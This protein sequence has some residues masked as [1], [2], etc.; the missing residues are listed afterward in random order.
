MIKVVI[1]GSGNV[2]QHLIAA[3]SKAHDSGSEIELLQ[4]YTRQPESL[5]PIVDF[6][7][8]TSHLNELAEADLYIIAISDD[9]IADFSSSLPFKNRLVV[10]TSGSLPLEALNGNNRKAVFYP[11]QTF[12]KTR[13][14]DFSNVPIA[15]ESENATD[16]QLLEK[17][18][19]TISEHVY[20]INSIQRKALHVSAVF[21]NNFSNHLYAIANEICNEHQISFELL[22]PLIMETAEKV[23]TLTPREAQT[24]P[25]RRND[26]NTIDSHLALLTND[27]QKAIYNLLTHSIQI[28]EEKL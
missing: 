21:V 3:L 1:I 5:N 27:N 23:M 26:H 11:L 10:H 9:A 19:K 18:A 12:S 13:E 14:V 24:G 6:D 20:A 8:V 4:V 16:F 7:K 28:H 25:A 2:A 15:L 22:K 17:V